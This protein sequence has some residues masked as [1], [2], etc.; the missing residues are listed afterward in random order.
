VNVTRFLRVR[1]FGHALVWSMWLAGIFCHRRITARGR[2]LGWS[3]A[4]Y[5]G[6]LSWYWDMGLDYA[7]DEYD[8][9]DFAP[10]DL[11]APVKRVTVYWHWT[12]W[13]IGFCVGSHRVR[14]E[15]GWWVDSDGLSVV[16][17]QVDAM[18]LPL[19]ISLYVGDCHA[20]IRQHEKFLQEV[21]GA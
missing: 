5:L 2:F 13:A 4:A 7:A 9:D 21:R 1:H 3:L 12:K 6:P 8:R 18:F 15:P 19:G 16:G 10:D 14:D 20:H 11:N 17:M